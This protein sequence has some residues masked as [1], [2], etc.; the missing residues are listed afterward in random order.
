MTLA[1]SLLDLWSSFESTPTCWSAFCN[2]INAQRRRVDDKLIATLETWSQLT[3]PDNDTGATFHRT[4][5]TWFKRQ[6]MLA[7]SQ[8][9]RIECQDWLR[10]A[11]VNNRMRPTVF[12][13]LLAREQTPALPGSTPLADLFAQPI[14]CGLLVLQIVACDYWH[15][16]TATWRCE[17]S[18]E[19]AVVGYHATPEWSRLALA[20]IDP[21]AARASR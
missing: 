3:N 11:L 18:I 5:R 1:D 10:L 9:F 14:E 6:A 16:L 19:S 4:T 21:T 8:R 13:Q 12:C 20:L 15:T 17:W 7:E 2:A